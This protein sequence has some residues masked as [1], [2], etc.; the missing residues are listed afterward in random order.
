MFEDRKYCFYCLRENVKI[1]PI[2]DW[3]GSGLIGYYCW[4]HFLE[5]KHFQDEQ[6]K[7]FLEYFEQLPEVE[8]EDLRD[9][10]RIYKFDC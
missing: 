8:K 2:Q 5:V 7:K 4:P 6:Q 3:T 9:M 1:F 10:R